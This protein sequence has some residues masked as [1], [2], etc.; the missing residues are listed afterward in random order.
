MSRGQ[1]IDGLDSVVARVT[2]VDGVEGFGEACPLGPA[3]L[4]GPRRRTQSRRCANSHP[5]LIARSCLQ[6]ERASTAPWTR[7]LV[8][9]R[10]REERTSTSPAGTSSER[11]AGLPGLRR[12]SAE[13]A[14]QRLSLST[15]PYRSGRGGRDVRELRPRAV[16]RRLHHNASSSSSA[17]TRTR[18]P[19]RDARR[20]G[21]SRSARRRRRRRR[22]R[23]L[24]LAG[25][26]LSRHA[27]SKDL[28]QTT[29]SSSR[30]T[31]LRG[32]P[33]RSGAHDA[34]DNPRRG[35]HG[36]THS[37]LRANET[38]GRWR[39]FNL[40]IGKVGGL[41]RAREDARPCPGARA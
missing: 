36:R 7:A 2:T 28:P 6:H 15:P 10:L 37:L 14:K 1:Q 35:H 8:G 26:R 29:S 11:M 39:R 25:M 23:G 34:S 5:R 9:H 20:A 13:S 38:Q 17:P 12:S 19:H 22:E 18:T 40:K 24:A 27:S 21:C 3:L 30:V 4:R 32:V 16:E 33:D 31:T 41:T